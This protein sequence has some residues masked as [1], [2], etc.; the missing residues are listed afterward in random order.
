MRAGQPGTRGAVPGPKTGRGRRG[1]RVSGIQRDRSAGVEQ[2][3]QPSGGPGS[4]PWAAA[5]LQRDILSPARPPAGFA[6]RYQPASRPPEVGGGWYDLVELH[7]GRI[8]MVVGACAG[9]GL[10]AATVM[11]QVRSACRALLLQETGPARALAVLDRFAALVPTALRTTVFCAVLDPG[12]GQLRYSSAGH[13]PG[14]LAHPGGQTQLLDGG[15][16]APLAAGQDA[17]RREARCTL[18]GRS[19]LLLYT[20]G[21]VEGRRV[22]PG[23]GIGRAAT[24]LHEAGEAGA[25]DLASLVIGGLAPPGGYDDDVA[26]VAYRHPSP[27]T[28]AFPAGPTQL[29]PV[30][31]A[32]RGWLGRSGVGRRAVQ[33]ILVAAGEACA[34]AIE[35]G[36]RNIP[37]QHI[38]LRAEATVSRLRV[39]ITDAGRWK[40]AQ[41]P[42][43]A[44]RGRGIALMRALMEQVSIE[45][46]TDGDGTT[47][48]MQLRI[49]P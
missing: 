25:D 42:D 9:H 29:A 26:L 22:P 20:G 13:P 1:L 19:A 31:A 5:A 16:A 43:T 18:P 4:L 12:T 46:G 24:T 21:L 3:D 17:P 28:L 8:G 7:G 47:V 30:R 44:F 35:H 2:R 41:P 10:A 27:L 11:G 6:A 37:G 40:A 39:T 14:I 23:A 33:D 38:R 45:P 49:A 34:N 15:R 36:H 48:R 32:L